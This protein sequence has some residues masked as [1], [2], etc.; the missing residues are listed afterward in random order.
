M[1][2][3][4]LVDKMPMSLNTRGPSVSSLAIAYVAVLW[5]L[6]PRLSRPLIVYVQGKSNCG[7]DTIKNSPSIYVIMNSL[8]A[9]YVFVFELLQDLRYFCH[10]APWN[11]LSVVNR[12]IYWF[13]C[14]ICK[15]RAT[16]RAELGQHNTQTQENYET[17]VTV[18]SV[19]VHEN[20]NSE[21]IAFSL[22]FVL[23]LY[24]RKFPD[25]FTLFP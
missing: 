11:P 13:P 21:W 20:Y 18:S 3:G 12:D 8:C 6:V 1:L 23:Q 24:A 10:N 7:N 19:K 4:L 16:I 14:V 5:S 9:T 22:H 17:T 2:T 15:N 25:N